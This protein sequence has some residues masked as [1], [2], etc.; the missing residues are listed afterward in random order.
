MSMRGRAPRERRE[1]REVRRRY[2]RARRRARLLHLRGTR[3]NAFRT[4][5]SEEWIE[6]R[7]VTDELDR[8]ATKYGLAAGLVPFSMRRCGYDVVFQR[9]DYVWF[10][11]WGEAA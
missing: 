7:R 2:R 9:P 4:I 6:F 11:L 5:T 1:Y 8:A 3:A 10:R